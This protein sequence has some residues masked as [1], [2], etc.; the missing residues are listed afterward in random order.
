MQMGLGIPLLSTWSWEALPESE[1]DKN[2]PHSKPPRKILIIGAGASGM[3]AALLLKSMGIDFTILEASN[4]IGGRIKQAADWADYPIDLGAEWIHTDPKV[5]NELLLKKEEEGS[6]GVMDYSP[7]TIQAWNNKKLKSHHLL[8][9]FYAEWKFKSSTWFSF[10]ETQ[11]YPDIREHVVLGKPVEQINYAEDSVEI[12]TR[13]GS[14]FSADKVILTCSVKCLQNN[15]IRFIPPLPDDTKAALE[16]IYMGDG[17]KVFIKFKES[18]YPDLL[19]F[20]P[21]LKAIANENKFFYN[22]SFGK[23]TSA[24]VLGLL[25]I[26]QEAVPYV[27]S[28][29]E[30][31]LIQLILKELDAVFEGKASQHYE[32]HLIQNWSRE[33]FV[34]GAYSY[35]YDGS[36]KRITEVLKTPVQKR[37]YFA[38]EALGGKNHSTVHGACQSGFAAVEE[39][40]K[41]T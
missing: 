9:H 26:N 35:T 25:A 27:S 19:F 28:P 6:W 10:F 38:G 12:L 18:F 16:Q 29:S 40:L 33:P 4:R 11:I 20:G 2:I 7:Q 39:I 8:K 30:N 41:S 17:I 24:C 21:I 32:K 34:Q 23:D 31:D 13:D 1:N 37:I 15:S 3:A 22:A 14:T 5:L 36:Q